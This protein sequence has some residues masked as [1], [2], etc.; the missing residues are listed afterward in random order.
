MAPDPEADYW[1][2]EDVAA[3]LG[4]AVRTV[5]TYRLRGQKGEPGGLPAEDRM[6]GRSPA[7]RPATITGWKR[8][9]SS[10]GRGRP[11]RRSTTESA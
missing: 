7:W 5:Y 2:V 1:V 3:Y 9:D 11:P 8:P 10:T 6:F 4:V